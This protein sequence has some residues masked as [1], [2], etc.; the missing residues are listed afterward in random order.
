MMVLVYF[1][2]FGGIVVGLFFV[3]LA[4]VAV[5]QLKGFPLT[6]LLAPVGAL[7]GEI[8]GALLLST[9]W[10]ALSGDPTDR[11]IGMFLGSFFGGILGAFSG[12]WWAREIVVRKR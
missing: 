6:W 5:P 3:A 4:T 2:L 8:A 9:L 7:I 11:D 12:L 10:P 1:L